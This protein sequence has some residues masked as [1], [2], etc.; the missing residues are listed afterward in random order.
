MAA[1]V[2]LAFMATWIAFRAMNHPARAGP[3]IVQGP[4]PPLARC[5]D[6]FSLGAGCELARLN[7]H[8][9]GL[10]AL[11]W[12]S[13]WSKLPAHQ[14]GTT[15]APRLAQKAETGKVLLRATRT[16]GVN[17]SRSSKVK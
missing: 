15:G 9:G 3:E 17:A 1:T 12:T 5:L 2:L 11:Q 14:A 10:F 8:C 4:S 13:W 7:R 16:A 6:R